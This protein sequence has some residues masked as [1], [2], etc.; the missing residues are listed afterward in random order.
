MADQWA[1]TTDHA[2]DAANSD[3]WASTTDH[4]ATVAPKTDDDVIR[5]N[6]LDPKVVKSSHLYVPGHLASVASDNTPHGKDFVSNAEQGVDEMGE[7]VYRVPAGLFQFAV[8]AANKLGIASDADVQYNDLLEKVHSQAYQQR[9]GSNH[10]S[11]PELAG[12]ALIP[13]PGGAAKTFLGALA[14]GAATG[15]AVSAAQPVIT[16]PNDPNSYAKQ[17]AEQVGIGTA[18]GVATGGLIHGTTAA[19][20]KIIN[21]KNT[22]LP[23]EVAADLQSKADQ[24]STDAKT[25]GEDAAGRIMQE[26]KLAQDAADQAAGEAIQAKAEADAAKRASRRAVTGAVVDARQA[27]A[28]LTAKQ[29]A[30]TKAAADAQE[31]ASNAAKAATTGVG[32]NASLA[33]SRLRSAMGDTPFHGADDVTAAAAG[34]DGSAGAVLRQLQAAGDNP[35]KIQQASIQLQNWRTRKVASG[36]YDKV[37]SIADKAALGD[38]PLDNTENVVKQELAKAEGAKIPDTSLVKTLRTIQNNIGAG[39][40]DASSF[41]E[42]P[43]MSSRPIDNSYGAIRTFDDHLGALIKSGQKGTNALISDTS[44]PALN[45]VRQAVRSDL[46][47]F[48]GSTPELQDAAKQAD[49]YYKSTRVPFKQPDIAKAATT[50]DPDQIY[51]GF[52]QAGAGDKAQRYYNALDPKGRA[53]VRYQMATDASNAATDPITG[54]FDPKKFYHALNDVSDAHGVF[55]KGGDAAEF[56]GLKKFAQQAALAQDAAK[57]AGPAVESALAPQVEAAQQRVVAARTALNQARAARASNTEALAQ[58]LADETARANAIA[59]DVARDSNARQLQHAATAEDATRT[60]QQAQSVADQAKSVS[61]EATAKRN[62]FP[63]GS[64]AAALAVGADVASRAGFPH[65]AM[66]S[67]GLGAAAA[68]VKFLTQTVPGRKF[69]LASSGLKVGSPAMQAL[70]G[71]ISKQAPAAIGR[72][73]TGPKVTEEESEP[74]ASTETESTAQSTPIPNF[75]PDMASSLQVGVPRAVTLKDGTTIKVVKQPDGSVHSQ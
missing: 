40:G 37:Q 11:I 69:L 50:P 49:D 53:A 58:S 31:A 38:V 36:L 46:N 23:E 32:Q 30:A 68:T 5:A 18:L 10:S 54:E 28:D 66:V 15:A 42:N 71:Q 60:A 43:D 59:E 55:F 6:G 62:K 56:T 14:K 52:V 47:K 7:G 67:G 57:T 12:S 72:L 2:P 64:A 4:A 65:T 27:A 17:K 63:L 35:D 9:V 19:F 41:Y 34:G 24:A 44:V 51:D 21:A 75:P 16:E 22:K 29:V 45:A 73:A 33:T 1:S 13:I 48:G 39:D 25:V 8:H 3:G 26:K 20:G 70:M 61:D 74:Y